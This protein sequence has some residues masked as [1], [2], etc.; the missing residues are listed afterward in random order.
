[1]AFT[2]LTKAVLCA[3]AL[4]SC[5]L[6][7]PAGSSAL[8]SAPTSSSTPSASVTAPA[9]T[10]TVPY[11]SDNANTIMWGPGWNG[12]PEAIRG[13]LGASVIG[14]QNVPLDLQNPDM[15]A[16]PT[17]DAGTVGNA[18]W[19]FSLSHNRL[20]TGGWAR[21][22]NLDVLPIATNMAG[23]NMRLEVGAIR[24]LHWHKTGE[25][26]YML[27][28]SVQVTAVNQNGQN[29]VS[30][31][32]QGDLWYFPAGIPHS[33]QATN[34]NSNGAE[35]LLVF[36]DG[37]F[38]ED[39]TFLLTDWLAHVPKDVLAKNFQTSMSTFD[40]IP[41]Q[42]LYIFP[43][44]PPGS[45]S[46]APTSPQGTVPN[47]FTFK[48]SEM[49]ATQ[50]QGGSVK[51]VDSTNFPASVTIAAAEVTVE[52]GAMRELHWHPT[53]DEWSFFIEGNARV[54][55]FA[56]QSSARTFDF[57]GGDVGYVP[58][59]YGHY[60]ENTGNTTLR[61]LEVFKTS[62]F[63]DVSLSQWLALTPAAMVKATL[64]LDD[65]A[66]TLFSKTKPVVV[67]PSNNTSSS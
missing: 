15:L 25:W 67:G 16:P 26:A 50:L 4:A 41:G 49:N 3:V 55:L 19:P 53:Q 46:D 63:Q 30:T 21:Q 65:E 56:A 17:T 13:S 1:M 20:Q 44:S 45:D 40:T 2:Q 48:M 60:V 23:V 10:E 34:A 7:A 47:P 27:Q 54:S 9:A 59:S 35:F 62:V 11:A 66:L 52:P 57:Q 24:E 37:T 18:K 31:I 58:A 5:S 28:G 61:Y 33:I 22:Q 8:A 12:Q 64:N 38:S 29:F 51:I 14:P 39:D 43:G 6:G 32:N 36:D 42:E